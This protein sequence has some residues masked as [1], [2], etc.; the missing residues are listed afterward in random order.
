MICLRRA[1]W[2]DFQYRL[3]DAEY[4]RELQFGAANRLRERAQRLQAERDYYR[5]RWLMHGLVH[6]RH[7][8][9]RDVAAAFARAR[10]RDL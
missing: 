10:E 5:R 2:R 3:A 7:H 1:A 9:G 4:S 8:R 6:S